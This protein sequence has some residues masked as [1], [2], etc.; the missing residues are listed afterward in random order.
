MSRSLRHSSMRISLIAAIRTFVTW[1][2]SRQIFTFGKQARATF[3]KPGLRSVQ[4]ENDFP[5]LD[6]RELHEVVFQFVESCFV[7]DINDSAGIR[8]RDN[9]VI[10][11]CIITLLQRIIGAGPSMEFIDPE[12]LRKMLRSIKTDAGDHVP[13]DRRRGL[14]VNCNRLDRVRSGS[15]F[16][17]DLKKSENSLRRPLE[18]I[19]EKS[20]EAML[21]LYE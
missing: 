21:K 20:Y 17:V 4:K 8:I 12:R 3:E 16:F 18:L 15:Q 13:D 5:A 19:V 7:K 10:F 9:A 6:Q 11:F 1:N 14:C 2:G